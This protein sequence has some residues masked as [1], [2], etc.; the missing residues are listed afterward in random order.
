MAARKGGQ[1]RPCKRCAPIGDYHEVE[2][3]KFPDDVW[4]V[5]RPNPAIAKAYPTGDES[6]YQCT[7]CRTYFFYHLWHPG[8]SCDAMV[9]CTHE[10]LRR[11]RLKDVALHLDAL[12]PELQGKLREYAG[13]CL[14]KDYAL[15]KKG[16]LAELDVLKARAADVVADALDAIGNR[17]AGSEQFLKSHNGKVPDWYPSTHLADLRRDEVKAACRAAELIVEYLPHAKPGG[18]PPA[19]HKGIA[20]LLEDGE[21][22]IRKSALKAL[23]ALEKLVSS[24]TPEGRR[25]A[26]RPRKA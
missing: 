16:V 7:D 10:S 22:S 17:H 15:G 14:W 18:L 25:L 26:S 24:T 5:V 1:K 13:T 19:Q 3:A 21:E 6:L 20:S 8:G 11:M 12:L 4:V 23:K 2:D 9:T